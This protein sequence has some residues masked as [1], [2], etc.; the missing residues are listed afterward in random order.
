MFDVID[1]FN[2]ELFCLFSVYIAIIINHKLVY[3]NKP[4]RFF[5]MVNKHSNNPKI[6][7]IHFAT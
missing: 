6:G 3:H 7:T 5:R 4:R 1:S 2:R